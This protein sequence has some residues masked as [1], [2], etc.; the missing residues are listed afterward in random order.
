MI[1]IFDFII[2]DTSA[3]CDLSTIGATNRLRHL[4]IITLGLQNH[5]RQVFFTGK[6]LILLGVAVLILP[7]AVLKIKINGL[8]SIRRNTLQ[9]VS[10][11]RCCVRRYY[12]QIKFIPGRNLCPFR[13]E[14][15]TDRVTLVIILMDLDSGGKLVFRF[16]IAVKGVT[17]QDIRILVFL[18]AFQMI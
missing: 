13:R 9:Q 8:G 4:K 2:L 15:Q 14:L 6:L 16:R 18:D 3:I 7:V 1:F 10:C 17:I 5:N 11:T 12:E